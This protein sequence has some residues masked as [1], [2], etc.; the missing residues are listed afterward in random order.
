[1][2]HILVILGILISTLLSAQ[3]NPVSFT[4]DLQENTIIFNASIENGWHLYA[5]NLPDPTS[6]PLPTEIVYNEPSP[7]IIGKVE[8]PEGHTEMDDAFGIEVK[9]FEKSAYFKQTFDK[10]PEH[11]SGTVYYMVCN[12]EMCI[13]L[14][15]PFTL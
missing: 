13:P 8:E 15:Y 1:M 12:D 3:E 2:K 5:A 4:I 11:V 9:Y 6:G 14:E 7:V 10:A